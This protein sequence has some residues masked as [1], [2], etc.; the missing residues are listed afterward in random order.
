MQAAA[1]LPG[2]RQLLV[3]THFP[4]FAK[5][6]APNQITGLMREAG[7]VACVFGHIH[8]AASP[9][10]LSQQLIDGVAYSLVAGDYLGF[11]PQEILVP[12]SEN[13]PKEKR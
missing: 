3:M 8:H 4:P 6:L 2:E 9:Y 10:C 11:K 5:N 13:L 12:S 7:A 1:Q